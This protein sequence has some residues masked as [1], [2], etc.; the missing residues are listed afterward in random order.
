[1]LK[2]SKKV[3][4][5]LLV[6]MLVIISAV[7]CAKEKEEA[8]D[9]SAVLM[10]VGDIEVTAGVVNF[11]T[12]YQQSLIESVYA[13]YMGEDVWT[14]EME[15]GVTYEESMK[16]AI[17][18]LLQETYILAGH[19]ADYNVSLTEEDLAAVDA[20]VAE[21]EKENKE[22]VREKV[23][24]S[25]ENIVEY[26]K[27]FTLGKKVGEYMKKDIDLEVSRDEAAQKRLRYVVYSKTTVQDG[28]TV[29]L[30]DKEI[31]ELKKEAEAFLKGAKAN[32][33]LEA[34]AKETET[35]STAFTFDADTSGLDKAIITAAD[36]LKENEFAALMDVE[37]GYYVVQLESEFD[38][39][40]TD[41]EIKNILK[42]RGQ[43]RYNELLEQW[44]K[45][46]KIT[47][48]EELWAKISL[49]A[50]KVNFKNMDEGT[51]EEKTEE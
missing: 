51:T 41:K 31:K 26:L 2:F 10:T 39:D 34:Y 17:I 38:S 15:D 13:S 35:E 32:G 33:S 18:E 29:D 14:M 22:N 19:A 20:A 48:N 46:V 43:E 40:A 3:V 50:L 6:A 37:D 28:A 27:A 9:E 4:A 23:S 16:E 36:A 21:F 47:V 25:K 1:M 42:E 8:L 49:D 5:L 7:G 24:A 12:R 30:S 44:K 11:Y 45:E